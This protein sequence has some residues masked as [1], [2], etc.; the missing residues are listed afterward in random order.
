MDEITGRPGALKQFH[1]ESCDAAHSRCA[2]AASFR[3]F[4]FSPHPPATN[5]ARTCLD[6]SPEARPRHVRRPGSPGRP[7]PSPL[8]V[9]ERLVTWLFPEGPSSRQSSRPRSVRFS[10]GLPVAAVRGGAAGC[11]PSPAGPGRP[12]PRSPADRPH[13]PPDPRPDRPHDP[14]RA[15]PRLLPRPRPEPVAAPPTAGPEPVAAPSTPRARAC[16]G[17]SDAPARALSRAPSTTQPQ[18]VAAP[19]TTRPDCP[20]RQALA[21]SVPGRPSPACQK[22]RSRLP[23]ATRPFTCPPRQASALS[24]SVP[25]GRP[26]DLPAPAAAP[27]R[28]QV[29]HLPRTGIRP[30]PSP[31]RCVPVLRRAP[32]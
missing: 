17:S 9:A 22:R 29:G 31:P 21:V 19:S 3:R 20:P 4:R 30:R 26:H 23:S 12:C 32:E 2:T 8:L 13:D 16:R 1:V 18:P 11:L 10:A 14:A 7:V 27:L 24:T 15:L 25:A 5:L 6:R 28:D